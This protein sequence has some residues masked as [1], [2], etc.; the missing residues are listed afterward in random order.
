MDNIKHLLARNVERSLP[1]QVE[2]A[3]LTLL[4]HLEQFTADV[5]DEMDESGD[6]DVREKLDWVHTN[7][8]RFL[9]KNV[10]LKHKIISNATARPSPPTA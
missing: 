4:G 10:R 5:F 3:Y 6:A 8:T 2:Y 1:Q 7:L 9:S